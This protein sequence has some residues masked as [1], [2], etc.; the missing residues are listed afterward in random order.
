MSNFI[1]LIVEDDPSQRIFLTDL[2]KEAKRKAWM[3]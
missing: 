3:W 1:A 2:L